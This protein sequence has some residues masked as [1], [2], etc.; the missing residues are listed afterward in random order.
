MTFRHQDAAHVEALERT[1]LVTLPENEF[2]AAP[3]DI[4]HEPQT[5]RRRQT[6]RDAGI[7][8]ASFLQSRD[9]F[10]R[11]TKRTFGLDEKVTAVAGAAQ[12]TRASRANRR[13]VHVAQSFAESRKAVERTPPGGRTERATGLEPFR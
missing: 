11:M 8:E 9:N 3:A 5:V 2:G 10:D 1:R 7:D 12:R 4:E 6:V 13:S